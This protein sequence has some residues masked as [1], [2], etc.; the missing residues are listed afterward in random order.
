[1]MMVPDCHRRLVKAFED[2][3]EYLKNEGELKDSKEFENALTIIE[4]ARE[5]VQNWQQ[6]ASPQSLN[7]LIIFMQNTNLIN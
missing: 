1:M 6:S 4:S 5:Q 7:K 3:S 2:L